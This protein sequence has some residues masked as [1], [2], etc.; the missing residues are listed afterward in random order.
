ADLDTRSGNIK[1]DNRLADNLSVDMASGNGT[2]IGNIENA[3]IEIASGKINIKNDAVPKNLN[4]DIA[5][6]EINLYIPDS[7]KGFIINSDIASG[8]INS[9]FPLSGYNSKD[10][11][12]V[13][14]DGESKFD[15]DISSGN[16]KICKR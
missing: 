8:N 16:V 3:N 12:K 15:F 4:V 9:E 11:V 2:F 14:G 1:I 5:S 6:G 7:K 10:G 13:Y